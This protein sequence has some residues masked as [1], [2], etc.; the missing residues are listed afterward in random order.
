MANDSLLT[1]IATGTNKNLTCTVVMSEGPMQLNLSV[2]TEP[3]EI[4]NLN[5]TRNNDSS[6]TVFINNASKNDSTDYVCYACNG[7]TPEFCS[8]LA[9]NTFVGGETWALSTALPS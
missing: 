9:F 8:F 3:K 6:I 5:F 2:V 7:E 1:E 4:P